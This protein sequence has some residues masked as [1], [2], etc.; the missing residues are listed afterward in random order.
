MSQS[1]KNNYKLK[2]QALQQKKSQEDLERTDTGAQAI[3]VKKMTF[4]SKNSFKYKNSS[5]FSQEILYKSSKRLLVN[6]Y[7]ALLKGQLKKEQMNAL[8]QISFLIG[9]ELSIVINVTIAAMVSVETLTEYPIIS[10]EQQMSVP[11]INQT[12]NRK[13]NIIQIE[14]DIHN[15]YEIT[16]LHQK[17]KT[18]INQ[19]KLNLDLTNQL[20]YQQGILSKFW[21]K[22]NLKKLYLQP[23][24]I[25]N[26]YLQLNSS[27]TRK[28]ITTQ[29]RSS[30]FNITGFNTQGVAKYN[31]RNKLYLTTYLQQILPKRDI[32]YYSKQIAKKICWLMQITRLRSN[33]QSQQINRQMGAN[34]SYLLQNYKNKPLYIKSLQ[35]K[36]HYLSTTLQKINRES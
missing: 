1:N 14:T 24:K 16:V 15:T 13:L 5:I 19:T 20:S 34:S 29:K 6:F 30:F 26:I 25:M 33:Q 23:I 32:K 7:K 35:S 36:N 18:N 17:F 3:L 11:L 27:H 9:V 22:L 8:K 31:K 4:I 28:Y 21:S 12:T 2:I 10:P